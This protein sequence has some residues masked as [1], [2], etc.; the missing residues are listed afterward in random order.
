MENV[1]AA[2]AN[3]LP[4]T[5]SSSSDGNDVRA[6]AS[7]VG[8]SGGF[9]VRPAK[10]YHPLVEGFQRLA[11]MRQ[12]WMMVA[13][14]ASIAIGVG[15]VMWS[16]GSSY[17]PLVTSN[18][19]YQ[20]SDIIAV[21]STANIDFTMDPTNG[22]VLVKDSQ[23]HRAR[24][25][26]AR[27]GLSTDQ[28]VGLELLDQDSGLGTSQFMETARFRRALEGEL[29]RTVTS[30]DQVRS[31]RVHLA[32]PER[33][34]FVRDNR[35]P[36]ASVFV[37]LYSGA[38]LEREQVRAITNLVATSI[39]ELAAENVSI[40]DQ[41]GNLLSD[42]ERTNADEETERQFEFAQR[43]EDSV[44][45]RIQG[46]LEPVIGFRNFKAEVSADVDFTRVETA[47]ELFNPDLIALRS[48]QTIDETTTG[49]VNG[50]I[51][52][53]LTNQPPQDAEVPEEVD[54]N[55]NPIN[56]PPTTSRSE[57]TRNFE[58]DRT[59]S[60]TQ[61]QVGRLRRLTVAVVVDDMRV[62]GPDGTLV[63]QAW[64]QDELNR[65]RILVQDAVGYDAAR[66]DSVSV[67]NSPFMAPE[68]VVEEVAFWTEPWFWD[69]MKMVLA[70]IFILILI[71]GVFRPAL[72]SILDQGGE[73]EI[74]EDAALDALDIDEE[75]ISDDKVTLSMSDEYLLPGPSETFEKQLDALR[76]LIAEDPGRVSL[77]MKHWIMSD[78]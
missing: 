59:L 5:S 25:E 29:A 12:L 46:I 71:F 30:L 8:D 62:P 26:I 48:E 18:E 15:V 7:S 77:V 14:A 31:A 75:A 28:T 74:E 52:G 19:N 69:I 50:G 32:I 21:L 27:A 66:G 43:V 22:I 33:S 42:F 78:D 6:N 56:T 17:R 1:P 23:L 51:P 64:T 49:Q 57:A 13:L 4:S 38:A 2:S 58:V 61:N 68:E 63:R 11:L 60:Y 39:P 20:V 67:I 76:G 45:R 53:A 54:E 34:V 73:E 55:G 41:R 9:D 3:N 36:T 72:R 44:S 65:L 70:G 47:E 10:K 35:R 24:L 16:Q 40:V 37:D